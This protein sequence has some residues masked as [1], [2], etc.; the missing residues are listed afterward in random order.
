M[1]SYFRRIFFFL[2]IYSFSSSLFFLFYNDWKVE[3]PR[4]EIYT[5]SSPPQR[6]ANPKGPSLLEE[7]M[8]GI[9]PSHKNFTRYS[10]TERSH[11]SLKGYSR[12][13]QEPSKRLQPIHFL[14]IRFRRFSMTSRTLEPRK[15]R[16]FTFVL[17]DEK[18]KG[19]RIDRMKE[20]RKKKY[21]SANET[22]DKARDRDA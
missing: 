12:V 1:L 13:L 19:K 6:P 15:D 8:P 5:F 14:T 10:L 22:E 7:K 16:I 3:T 20:R 2:L 17:E 4:I 11:H 9:G 21:S 18:K